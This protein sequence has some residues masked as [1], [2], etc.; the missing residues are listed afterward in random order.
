MRTAPWI[1]IG[2]EG[3]WT[4]P[5]EAL[6]E[7]DLNYSVEQVDAFDDRGTRIPGVVVNRREDTGEILGH[8]TDRYGV[9]QNLDAFSLLD[10]F[11]EAGGII[12]HAGMDS[13]GMVFMVMRMPGQSFG[14]DGDSFDLYVCAM[15]SFNGS[16]PLAVFVSPLRVYCQNMF[17]K[18]VNGNDNVLRIKHGTFANDRIESARD[19][20]AM[21]LEYNDSFVNEL[22][23]M[24]MEKRSWKDV[25]DWIAKLFPEVPVDDLHPRAAASNAR[26]A[27][28]RTVFLNEFY[29]AEDNLNYLGTKLGIINAYYDWLSHGLP[30][31]ARTGY[32]E[33]RF[34]NMMLGKAVDAKLITAA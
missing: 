21:L 24:A 28:M 26:I 5:W 22:D 15:N 1:G 8:V 6:Q 16:F 9:I 33:R 20:T 3:E 32:E 18:L 34:D 14:F 25:D 31:R 27:E 19:A 7:A 10:P 29:Q 13:N 12:E 17:R 11:S 4:S 30:S 23:K 2:T